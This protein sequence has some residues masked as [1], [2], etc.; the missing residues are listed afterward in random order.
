MPE[1]PPM[2]EKEGL[3]AA[4]DFTKYLLTL[5]GGAIAFIIQ[6]NSNFFSGDELVKHLSLSSLC[7]L[8]ICVLSGLVVF[9]A[10]AV[11]L[12]RK[13]YNLEFR[14]IKWA[15]QV[16]VFSFAIGFVL[17][18][19]VV[20]IKLTTLPP[21]PNPTPPHASLQDKL[22]VARVPRQS[23]A[24]NT[25]DAR[26]GL[27]ID[28]GSSG[29]RIYIYCWKPAGANGIP[30]VAAA[31]AL[32]GEPSWTMKVKTR[33]SDV[34]DDNDAENSLKPLINYALEKIGNDPQTLAQTP[35]YLMATAGMRLKA[36]DH[37]AQ[38]KVII[39]IVDKYLKKTFASA[40]ST[41]ISGEEEA[42]YGWI[43][44][45]YLMGFLKEKDGNSSP[46]MGTL[47]LGGGSTQI[48]YA[49]S[50]PPPQGLATLQWGETTYQ[51]YPHSLGDS[52]QDQALE[53]I[54]AA[55]KTDNANK[56]EKLNPCYPRG[57]S[58]R[59]DADLGKGTGVY[60]ACKQKIIDTLPLV[61]QHRLLL[62]GAF[63]AYSGY[64]YTH[65][66]F[67]L[68][69]FSSLANLEEAGRTYCET[70]W[71]NLTLVVK[72]SDQDDRYFPQYCFKAAYIAALLQTGYG[73]PADTRQIIF[74]DTL[75]GNEISWTLGAMIH[76]AGAELTK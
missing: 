49:S 28:A 27:I 7:L 56:E 58:K 51:I 14:H 38:S 29:S 53:K 4:I 34:S 32:E 24:C 45:N 37:P 22:P 1:P 75:H 12:A 67:K 44:V 2:T 19:I 46:T 69:P 30:W 41:V 42:L 72:Y 40:S 62:H 47:E 6:P 64:Y 54:N 18:A 15:G 17:L 73:F 26:Y 39:R 23:L 20:G 60:D 65:S 10:G 25:V 59:G 16:N 36:K 68:K 9:S 8:V 50:N 52:G 5:S 76:M 71:Q 74:T 63:L 13:N 55:Y 35:L 31:P 3:Q 33:L 43:A 66:F 70:D 21:P 61:N 57:Y 48:A 11:M